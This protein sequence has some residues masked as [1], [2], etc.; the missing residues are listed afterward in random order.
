MT[1]AKK[2]KKDIRR[3]KTGEQVMKHLRALEITPLEYPDLLAKLTPRRSM[4][5]LMRLKGH[6]YKEIG[7]K[8]DV[9]I[10]RAHHIYMKALQHML[11]F[12]NGNKLI[13]DNMNCTHWR[14]EK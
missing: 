3:E 8:F 13:V 10:T 2:S 12:K 7:I 5:F 6:T 4:T 11:F 1:N 9:S 14:I